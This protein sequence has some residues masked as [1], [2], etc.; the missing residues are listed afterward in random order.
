M[1]EAGGASVQPHVESERRVRVGNRR[2]AEDGH[3]QDHT[4]RDLCK[5][6]K[7]LTLEFAWG[8]RWT[9]AGREVAWGGA[10]MMRERSY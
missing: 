8:S 7:S 1:V 4:Q 2:W 3:P 10:A 6:C 5:L 9:G